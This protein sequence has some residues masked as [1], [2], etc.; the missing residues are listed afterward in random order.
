MKKITVVIGG[1]C[2]RS[3]WA[4]EDAEVTVIDFDTDGNEE[5]A[6]EATEA[7]EELKELEKQGKMGMVW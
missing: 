7:F 5:A 2:C 6:D 3:V 1:G 4:D